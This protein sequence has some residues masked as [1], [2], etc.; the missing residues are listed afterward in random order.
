VEFVV[1]PEQQGDRPLSREAPE[2]GERFWMF[3]DLRSV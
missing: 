3:G 1:R 2:F